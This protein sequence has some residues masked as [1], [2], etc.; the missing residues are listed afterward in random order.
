MSADEN[1]VRYM[2]AGDTDWTRVELGGGTVESGYINPEEPYISE[3]RDFVAA[4]KAQNPA[5]FPNK[6]KDDWGV[7]QALHGLEQ[8]AQHA[9][10]RTKHISGTLAKRQPDQKSVWWE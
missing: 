8:L 2:A 4:A 10:T 3:M 5:L 7:R 1:C 6:L 9:E